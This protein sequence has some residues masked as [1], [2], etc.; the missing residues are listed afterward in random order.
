MYYK[1]IDSDDG[2]PV[3]GDA[4]AVILKRKSLSRDFNDFLFQINKRLDGKKMLEAAEWCDKNL[5]DDY[6]VGKDIS[7][8][9]NEHDAIAFKLRW[10]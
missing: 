10:M 5:K 7:G 2:Y 9:K 1:R 3:C 6:L 4:T 8:F